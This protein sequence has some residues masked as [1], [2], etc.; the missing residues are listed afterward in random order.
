MLSSLLCI[1][2]LDIFYVSGFLYIV[3]F[4]YQKGALY[5]LRALGQR[6]EMDITV[7]KTDRDNLMFTTE[8][9]QYVHWVNRCV[10]I[11]QYIRSLKWLEHLHSSSEALG[12]SLG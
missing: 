8:Q 11:S 2:N 5:R 9:D 12:L 7:G 10:T 3:Q 4:F 1:N 6:H